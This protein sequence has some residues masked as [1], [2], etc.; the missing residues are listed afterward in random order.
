M[1]E[2]PSSTDG[3]GEYA[4]ARKLV[5][6]ASNREALLK[7]NTNTSTKQK[8]SLSSNDLDD[9]ASNLG[10]DFSNLT[11]KK[12]HIARPCWTCPDGAIYLEAFH[13]L[14]SSA[15]DFLVAI[16]EPVA[17]PEFLHEYKITP[18]SL[19]AAVATNIDTE[20]IIRVL[21]RL[22]KNGLPD[23][24]RKFIQECTKRYGKAKLVLKHNRFYVESEHHDVL[25]EL[26]RDT[27]ISQARI[28]EGTAQPATGGAAGADPA[29]ANG[30]GATA[31]KDGFVISTRAEEME[32]NLKILQESLDGEDEEEDDDMN[33]GGNSNFNSAKP[34]KTKL[35]VAFQIKP[36]MVEI[37]KKQAIDLDYPLMEEYD[38]RNDKLNPNVPMDLKPHA[39]I[40]RYQERSLAKMFGNGRA[41]SGIIVLPCGAGKTLTGVTASQTIKKSV[42][43]LCTN[44]VSVLQWKY[45]FQLWTDIPD[46]RITCF[47]SDK[48]ESLHPESCV[49]I[50]TY[51]MISYSGK[52]SD[53]S[54]GVMDA[55][56]SRE[57]GLMLMD[58]VHVV[59]AKMFRRVVSSVKAHCRLGLTATLVR[60]DD[61]ISDLNFLIGPKL[62]EANW[63]DLTAQGYLANVQ[64]VEVWCPMTGPFMKEYLHAANARVKQLLYVM[65]P[66][67]L[68]AVEYLVKFHEARGD[69]IIVFSD[70]VFSV[71]EYADM[72]KKPFI[73]GETPE[74]ERQAILGLF[75]TTMAVQTICI[76]KVGDTS[77]DLPEANVVIQ[78]SSHFGS[79]RQ[80]AQ[81][82][83]R[84]LR[85]KSY[86]QRDGTNRSTFNAFFYTLVSTDTQEMYY[87][88]KRQQYLI[89]QGYTFKIVTN[90][91]E[92][93]DVEAKVNG[94]RYKSPEDDR[95]LLRRLLTLDTEIEKD[96]KA[97]DTA[98]RKNNKDGS[99]LAD[100]SVKRSGGSTM[101]QLSGGS[102]MRYREMGGS[103][104]KRHPL[105]A[106]RKR[107]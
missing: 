45:Q 101:A 1:S 107:T 100:E 17:R 99:A 70:L 65:N 40:R 93:C 32:E 44:A 61:L 18:Y 37:V 106:K 91:C 16:A 5:L 62:Y 60:E 103:S 77:I 31:D 102:G 41:R 3:E 43:C 94:Y 75:R 10:A 59:P 11:L 8:S 47:T 14:Y 73:C 15:Y 49:L 74:K 84:I 92:L 38:F 25:R 67:K 58:E 29:T 36:E 82:L 12:D 76:S 85:P 54:K 86:T 39:R 63:M 13:S 48:K 71:K 34:K 78:V 22:S 83:G 4:Q 66:S 95:E 105:F 55:I 72:L 87:S 80:E 9:E 69:K 52:R 2:A 79:R 33:D 42:I 88:A 46:D 27:K 51:T 30:N 68:R 19:Y 53:Q 104:G 98:I 24:V 20:S 50:T 56:C 89:D 96:Q 81:R 26:L 28:V 90:L 6:R 21:D 23:S 64:C 97:E 57:W 35:S 7:S